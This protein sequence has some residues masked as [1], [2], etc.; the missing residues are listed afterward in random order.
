[1]I[2]PFAEILNELRSLPTIEEQHQISNVPGGE[3]KTNISLSS[4]LKLQKLR[5]SA[6]TKT[7]LFSHFLKQ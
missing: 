1:M 7:A 2:T 6:A 3:L 4:A 5:H